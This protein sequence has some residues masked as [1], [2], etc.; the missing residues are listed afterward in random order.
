V[1]SS[2]EADV[3]PSVTLRCWGVRGS[4]PTPG[5]GTSRFGG[6]TACIE[7]RADG[8]RLIFDAGTDIRLLGAVMRGAE[9]PGMTRIFLTHFH[10]DHIQDFPFFAPVY[11]SRSRLSIAGPEQEEIDIRTL[12]AGQMGPVYFPIPFSAVAAGTSFSHLNEGTWEDQGFE[13]T[14]FR[15]RHASFTVGYRIRVAGRLICYLLD[16]ELEGGT[17]P[18][19]RDAWRKDL[20]A[21]L[22]DTDVLL[23]D[24]MY[25]EEEYV[26]RDRWGHSTFDQAYELAEECGAKRLLFSHPPLERTD[27]EFGRVVEQFAERSEREGGPGVEAAREGV[28]AWTPGRVRL[29]A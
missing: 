29:L 24:A 25:T 3:V 23:H 28:D 2:R 22:R 16:N 21:F 9:A 4:I 15:M 13:V 20:D 5:P 26:A 12:F 11:D 27:A 8:R 7:L 6:N 14:P 10:W 18:V 17:Y 19:G 1:E